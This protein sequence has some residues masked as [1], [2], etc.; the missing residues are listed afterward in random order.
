M[1][2]VTLIALTLTGCPEPDPTHTHEWG[3]WQYD[4]TQ[5]W[6]ECTAND[7]EEYGRANHTSDPCTVCGYAT[8]ATPTRDFKIQMWEKDI[9]VT[10]T[11]TGATDK[12]LS[13]LKVIEKLK[14]AII[15]LDVVKDQSSSKSAFDKVLGNGMIVIIEKPSTPYDG[16]K[17]KSD[18]KTIMFDIDYISKA[19]TTIDDIAND[20]YDAVMDYLSKNLAKTT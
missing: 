12:D 20:L 14:E 6:K 16:F 2:I 19:A 11:R 9:T 1:A 3:A 7:G 10:D 5:H 13:E 18:G 4:A 17:T 15:E 8:P